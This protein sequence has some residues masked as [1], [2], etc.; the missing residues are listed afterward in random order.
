MNDSADSAKESAPRGDIV[1]TGMPGGGKSAAG[2]AL[3]RLLRRELVET[4]EMA[5]Q[6]A[7]M[8]VAD[9]FAARGEAHFR[10]L[11][12]AALRAALQ[13]SGRVIST[14]GGVVLDRKNRALIRGAAR[15]VYLQAPP[16]L[17]A[18]RLKTETAARPLLRGG[19]LAAVLAAMLSRRETWYRQTA[20]LTVA[21]HG[22]DTPADVAA[23]IRAGL[24]HICE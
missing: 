15:A 6:S 11:E 24:R 9:I 19:D 16:E 2:R 7:G 12:S 22:D 1:L 3:A 8:S 17:L 13:K 23:K 4:D 18:R 21:Q 10:K 14:G 5:A 20:H